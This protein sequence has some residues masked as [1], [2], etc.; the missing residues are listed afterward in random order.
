[1]SYPRGDPRT[2]RYHPGMSRSRLAILLLASTAAIGCSKPAANQDTGTK[3]AAVEGGGGGG[4]GGGKVMVPGGEGAPTMTMH[5]GSGDRGGP[6]APAKGAEDPFKLKAEEGK[7]AIESPADAKA[8]AEA[9]ATIEVTPGEGYH[10]NTEFPI[11]LTL[12]SPA[13]VSLAKAQFIAGGH[14][15][16]KGDAEFLDETRL[17]INV[18]LTAAQTGNYMIN[19]T[20]KF[21]VCDKDSCLAKKE[22]IAIAVAAK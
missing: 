19:G 11:K 10:V 2:I 3:A 16:S 8:G 20:F 12:E 5:G 14:D 1:M 13:G 7:L 6:A 9:T 22:T 4:G 18:K 21:A 17:S 15:K